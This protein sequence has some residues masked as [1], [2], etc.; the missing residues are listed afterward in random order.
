MRLVYTYFWLPIGPHPTVTF[1]YFENTNRI[2]ISD[3]V[4]INHLHTYLGE[5]NDING[6]PEKRVSQH[7]M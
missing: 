6:C 1:S 5:S 3:T 4:Y 7:A 2:C